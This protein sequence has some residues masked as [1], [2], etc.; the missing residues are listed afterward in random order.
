MVAAEPVTSPVV[1]RG[2]IMIFGA[3]GA[4]NITDVSPDAVTPGVAQPP[5]SATGQFVRYNWNE[6]LE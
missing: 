3:G 6:V 4:Y 5:S 2:Q 1:M